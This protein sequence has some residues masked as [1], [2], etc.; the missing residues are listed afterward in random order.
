M[1]KVTS[2]SE[3]EILE[4][5][6][7]FANYKYIDNEHGMYAYYK[8][9]DAVR[10]YICDY[11]RAVMKRG[12]LYSTSENHEAY[13]SFRTSKDRMFNA[14]GLGII[15]SL[16]HNMGFIGAL[17]FVARLLTAGESFDAKLRKEKKDF[18][19]VGLLVVTEPYQG[20]GYMRKVLEIAFEEGRKRNCPVYLETDGI[21]KRDKYVS[22][23]ME[24]VGARKI[25]DGSYLFDLVKMP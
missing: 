17:N 23:G 3:K 15:K 5:G 13:I 11:T 6:N 25:K 18:I 20:K 10:D 7:A 16:I 22:L 1:V 2:L 19:V 4:I 9:Y 12:L 24:Y 21:E 14:T 8:D